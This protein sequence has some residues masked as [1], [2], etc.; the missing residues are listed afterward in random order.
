MAHKEQHVTLEKPK[1]FGSHAGIDEN[2]KHRHFLKGATDPASESVVASISGDLVS[3][4]FD[5]CVEQF[6][7]F[8]QQKKLQSKSNA[9]TVNVS[10]ISRSGNRV[11]GL[12]KAIDIVKCFSSD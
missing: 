2:A 6:N 11:I 5:N 1:D 7:N 12:F 10:E 9:R 3:K 4:S 8:I